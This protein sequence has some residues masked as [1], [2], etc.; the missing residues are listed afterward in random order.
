MKNEMT[1]TT[2]ALIPIGGT[3]TQQYD[4]RT[5]TYSKIDPFKARVTHDPQAKYVGCVFV[6]RML[7]EVK[8]GDRIVVTSRR[9]VFNLLKIGLEPIEVSLR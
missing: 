3:F 4:G 2:F 8:T 9:E 6:M 1:T 7:A 5:L